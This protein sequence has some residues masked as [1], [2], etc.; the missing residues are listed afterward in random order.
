MMKHILYIAITGIIFT[1][2]R[3]VSVDSQ[4]Q[5]KS[6]SQLSLGMIGLQETNLLHSNFQTTA[7][8]ELKKEIRISVKLVPFDNSSFKAYSK[9]SPNNKQK[10][11]F[12]DSIKQKP[13]FVKLQLMDKVLLMDELSQ[14]YNDEV[15]KYLERQKDARLV[16]SLSVALKSADLEAI[17]NA[18]TVFLVGLGDKRYGIKL[19]NGNAESA[20]IGFDKAT[21]FAH[22]L[23]YFCWGKGKR[24]QPSIF[25][26]VKE[27]D[28]CPNNTFREATKAVDVD[29]FLKF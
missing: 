29:N 20:L 14:L 22:G 8:P 3:T 19:M 13:S 6:N 10:V 18:K 27:G 2:C 12:A 4:V 23:S 15:R 26:I 5:R 17:D 21:V 9:N 11:N 16:T 7:L 28:H 1:A 24:N 25:D